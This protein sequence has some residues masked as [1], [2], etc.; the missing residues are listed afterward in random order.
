MRLLIKNGHVIDPATH[1]DGIYDILIEDDKIIQ[2]SKDIQISADEVI[3][4]TD[5]YIMPGF[6]DLHVHL[7]EPG[8]EYKETILTGTQA[9]AKGGFTTICPMPNTKP[10]TDNPE[11]VKDVVEKAKQDGIVHVLPIGAITIGQ[12]GKVLADIK[13]MIEAGVVALSED[14][15]SVMNSALYL[16]AMTIAKEHN[17]PIFAHCE[18]KNL[19][20]GG[21]MNAGT[22]AQ[23]LGLPGISNSV[24]DII[25]ARDIF[26]AKESG[27]RLHLC[28]CSTKDSVILVKMAKD[29][30][31][32]VTAEV[33]PHH[34][35]LSDQ[36]I[37][38]DHGNYKMN[39]PL[40]GPEDVEALKEGL[41]DNIMDAIATDHAPHGE[42]ENN[43]SMLTAPFGIVGLET[44]LS[45]TV[46]E[47]VNKGYL[48]PMEMVKHLS[49]NPAK[50][51]GISKGSLEVGRIADIVIADLKAIDTIYAKDMV[52][53]GKNMP[54]EGKEVSG[55]V[56]MT[57]VSGKV[58]YDRSR[59][60]R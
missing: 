39:P 57:I 30:N 14:G 36:D 18:D 58:V 51:L 43:T 21:V 26:L 5:R 42:E 25:A 2:V 41:K 7:R 59:S 46:T 56:E 45:L 52:S 12:E 3:D 11:V 34:F 50:I 35:T 23:E 48:T 13:G 60:I 6:I 28:H 1:I 24:E 8:Y 16:K 4:G 10:V 32:P 40:R 17:I 38:E 44:A 47:L 29:M 54:F 37:L 15:K 27:A 22:K 33:C 49:Y 55:R 20:R 31:L 9:A 19:V 53:K